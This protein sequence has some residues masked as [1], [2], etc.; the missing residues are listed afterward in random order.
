MILVTG[1]FRVSPGKVDALRPH[2]RAVIEANRNEDG[3]L[4]FAYGEDVLDPGL[5]RVV[6]RWRDWP[7]LE[8]HARSTHV[9]T[10]RAAL[11]EIGVIEREVIAH[12]AGEERTL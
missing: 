9:A 4:L 10:W 12:A 11:K 8:A 5:L 2:M 3:C 6:E 7:S 1:H